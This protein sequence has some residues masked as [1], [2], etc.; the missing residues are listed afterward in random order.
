MEARITADEGLSTE[1]RHGSL[2]LADFLELV[3]EAVV[4]SSRE[5]R[6]VHANRAAA[7][8][9]GYG[10]SELPGSP[11]ETLVPTRYVT[12][13]VA[14]R[15]AYFEDPN[16]RPVETGIELRCRRRDGGEFPAEI[17]IAPFE[18]E[19]ESLLVV[20]VRDVGHLVGASDER[21]V[22]AK[23]VAGIGQLAGGIAHDFNNLL[24]VVQESASLALG[25]A[26]DPELRGLLEEIRRAVQHGVELTDQLLA[27]GRPGAAE[28]TAAD[29]NS[30]IG[31]IEGLLRRLIGA[32]RELEISPDDSLPPVAATPG[33]L[34][35]VLLNLVIN[36]RDA[37]PRG[38]RISIATR[39]TRNEAMLAVRDEGEGMPAEVVARAVDPFFSTKPQGTGLGLA[40]VDGIVRR[41]GGRIDFDS[42]PG[43]GTTVTVRLPIAA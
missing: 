31:G 2:E 3:P 4:V 26:R 23:R 7:E 14:E 10:E 11:V 16:R 43:G 33:Q 30:V 17:S 32:G 27:F 34:E 35:Q 19:G 25:R 12:A 29:L 9:F 18:A 5:G 40:T 37:M 1:E 20:A 22:E 28:E 8:L 15:H 21:E 39:R 42:A 36:A 13:H 6:I 38:G 41:A 24:T